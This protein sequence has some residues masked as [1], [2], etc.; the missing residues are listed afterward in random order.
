MCN[1]ITA[2]ICVW[3]NV[4]LD[5]QLTLSLDGLLMAIIAAAWG[6]KSSI[7]PSLWLESNPVPEAAP[8]SFRLTW[9]SHPITQH[10]LWGQ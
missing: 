10:S 2:N 7:R 1:L 6:P 8:K 3:P 9:I 5:L 4:G